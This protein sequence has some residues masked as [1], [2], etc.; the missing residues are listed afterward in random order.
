MKLL[1]IGAKFPNEINEIVYFTF[2][3]R[4]Y[5]YSC[6]AKSLV[7][8]LLIQKEDE[9]RLVK[10]IGNNESSLFYGFM[11]LIRHAGDHMRNK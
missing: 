4:E 8:Q 11:I 7:Q 6:F 9:R 2:Y 1:N 10:P 3:F 5:D